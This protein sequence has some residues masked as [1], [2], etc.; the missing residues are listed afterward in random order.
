MRDSSGRDPP[1][2]SPR[3][4]RGP[5][6]GQKSL[7]RAA[8]FRAFL[9]AHP[10]AYLVYAKHVPAAPGALLGTR[11]TWRLHVGD[12]SGDVL[13]FAAERSALATGPIDGGTVVEAPR[14]PH[15]PPA[16]SLPAALVPQ[17]HALAT[18]AAW[19][20]RGEGTTTEWNVPEDLRLLSTPDA[21]TWQVQREDAGRSL[22]S[23]LVSA[24]NGQVLS[25]VRL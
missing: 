1:R 19:L 9:D 24:A 22:V 6:S 3:E 2:G 12:P 14:R 18:A 8:R 10:G 7:W 17:S 11:A 25:R 13:G 21:A 23:L 16:A 20:G 15:I 5:Y 4:P